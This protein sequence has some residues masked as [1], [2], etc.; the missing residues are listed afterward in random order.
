[1]Y[2]RIISRLVFFMAFLAQVSVGAQNNKVTYIYYNKSNPEAIVAIKFID[3]KTNTIINTFDV[4]AN[5]PYNYLKYPIVGNN[6]K[7]KIYNLK[8]I[9]KNEL[10]YFVSKR[11]PLEISNLIPVKA[12]SKANI[13]ESKN[14]VAISYILNTINSDGNYINF[15]TTTKIVDKTGKTI[16]IFEH[17]DYEDNN[18]IISP[19]G[20]FYALNYGGYIDN[21]ENMLFHQ[22]YRIYDI[23]TGHL[24]YQ[25]EQNAYEQPLMLGVAENNVF[26]RRK[27]V[28]LNDV[29]SKIMDIE[30]GYIG[31]FAHNYNLHITNKEIS[32]M[33][34]SLRH[35]IKNK[36][37]SNNIKIE[38]INFYQNKL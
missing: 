29:E 6:F 16:K 27:M 9:Q 1:M 34:E 11:K 25:E 17:L 33:T 32:T 30:L 18:P 13:F 3:V 24:L 28:S 10:D 15:H 22:G 35:D 36:I 5:N 12:F 4:I 8:N 2:Q 14:H 38:N 7:N 23:K 21:N 20:Q 26:V 37:P 19:N 31:T